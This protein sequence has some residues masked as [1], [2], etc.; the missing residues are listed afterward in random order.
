MSSKMFT[1]TFSKMNK[2]EE[3]I[4]WN[5]WW[6]ISPKEIARKVRDA[7][8]EELLDMIGNIPEKSAKRMHNSVEYIKYRL[9]QKRLKRMEQQ[10]DRRIG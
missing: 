1:K 8:Y 2:L 3:N 5:W 9:A 7:T 10:L 4:L 6:N